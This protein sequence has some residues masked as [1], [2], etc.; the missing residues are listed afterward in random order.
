MKREH[1][2]EETD[3]CTGD[4]CLDS[5][6]GKCNRVVPIR[7]EHQEKTDNGPMQIVLGKCFVEAIANDGS[8]QAFCDIEHHDWGYWTVFHAGSMVR[9][10]KPV[11]E[12]DVRGFIGFRVSLCKHILGLKAI[13]SKVIEEREKS[14]LSYAYEEALWNIR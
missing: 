9:I 14:R 7:G 2:A 3:K 1:E 10:L 8:E 13:Y 11:N 4:V 5:R 6:D 12:Y